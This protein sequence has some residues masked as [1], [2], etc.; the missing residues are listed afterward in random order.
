MTR[1][2]QKKIV[3]AVLAGLAASLAFPP[4]DLPFFGWFCLLP[5]LYSLTDGN[6]GEH[7]RDGFLF[8]AVF[9]GITLSWLVHV[10]IPGTLFLVALLS[11]FYGLF[12]AAAGYAFRKE[13]NPIA[14]PAAWTVMEYVRS[15]IFTGFPWACLGYSQ[16]ENVNVIQVA[17]ITG[18]YGISFL[19]VLVST[20][21]LL[22]IK[23]KKGSI[24]C[25]AAALTFLIMVTG[26]GVYRLNSLEPDGK[27]RLSVIQGNIPQQE[28]WD[29]DMSEK[30]IGVYRELTESSAE[31]DSD[32]IIWPETSYPY[33][34]EDEHAS[35]DSLKELSDLTGRP[36]L[37][38][39]V[40][41]QGEVFYNSAVL[42][43]TS[44]DDIRVYNKTH[45]VPFGEYIPLGKY[46][47][48]IREHIDKPIG[49]FGKGD[50]Y[51]LFPLKVTIEDAPFLGTRIREI[52][53]YRF[54]VLI[55]FED[56]FPYL[57]REFVK[58][59]ADFIVNITNDAW[60]GQTAASRQHLQA[61]VMRAVE[62]RRP[63]IRAANT[64]ISCFISA[65]GTVYS[66]VRGGGEEIF[67]R[68]NATDDIEI[69]SDRA[70]YTLYGDVFAGL[71]ALVLL[72]L[73]L[74]RRRS[75]S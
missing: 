47:A 39:A 43:N 52:R 63:L 21:G 58:K 36:L 11:L 27:V 60:F 49:D 20:A 4:F 9:L 18:F 61:S 29:P 41:G 71:C 44:T 6:I 17:D 33:L 16:Y 35:Y 31:E 38:G 72:F 57:T 12:A 59:G 25:I 55:C 2:T 69:Y 15:N 1:R 8:G 65:K 24:R 37:V 19:M 23:K 75:A 34:I 62:N 13:M 74:I 70:F 51:V 56:I 66:V 64:G 10:T 30:I 48:F 5:L 3:L 14:V 45:L 28:K 54:G 22:F 32:M 46:F 73:F 53:F 42:F 26:Y 50:E 40:Y 68:G 7:I 67:V